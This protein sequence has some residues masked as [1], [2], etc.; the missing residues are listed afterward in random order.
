MEQESSVRKKGKSLEGLRWDHAVYRSN[1]QTAVTKST[2]SFDTL[3]AQ[4]D[5]R[6]AHEVWL[7]R[8]HFWRECVLKDKVHA[9]GYF[10]KEQLALDALD[11]LA[12][13]LRKG[14]P[15]AEVF[16][17]LGD[18]ARDYPEQESLPF[19]LHGTPDRETPCTIAKYV[20]GIADHSANSKNAWEQ[21]V[22]LAYRILG[23]SIDRG[24]GSNE[25]ARAAAVDAWYVWAIAE[26][27]PEQEALAVAYDAYYAALGR[28]NRYATDCIPAKA[29]AESKADRFI[30]TQMKRWLLDG[31]ILQEEKRG[32]KS[33]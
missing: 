2:D 33:P 31:G 23:R 19:H 20:Q 4:R 32:P 28:P 15:D 9:A 25:S 1:F 7:E 10:D 12:K 6:P 21:S 3:L 8:F 29:G 26:K 18:F 27:L 24:R 22:K 5:Q 11:L 17:M 16:A 14:E 13:I 30:R